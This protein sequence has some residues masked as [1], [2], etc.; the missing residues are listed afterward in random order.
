MIARLHNIR[1]YSL[2]EKTGKDT[3]SKMLKEKKFDQYTP[4]YI[5]TLKPEDDRRL[6]FYFL[7]QGKLVYD[8]FLDR[9]IF[10]YEEAT[11]V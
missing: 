1:A 9:K 4:Q 11:F 3:I 8:P 6:E 7:I 5:H 10:F 2:P